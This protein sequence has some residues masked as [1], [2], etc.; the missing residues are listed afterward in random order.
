[1][2][3]DKLNDLGFPSNEDSDQLE[4][5]SDHSIPCA[6]RGQIYIKT[7]FFLYTDSEDTVIQ[8]VSVAKDEW[9]LCVGIQLIFGLFLHKSQKLFISTH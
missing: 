8:M 5:I 7:F 3:H 1:M 2:L 4:L 6:L 9:L